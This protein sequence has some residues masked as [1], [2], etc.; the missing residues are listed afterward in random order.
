M[1][2][3]YTPKDVA[4]ILNTHEKTVRKYL[5]DG[6]IEGQKLDGNWKISK[7]V[8]MSYMDK[9]QA[10]ASTA[11]SDSNVGGGVKLS[12]NVEIDV[13]HTKEGHKLA[14]RLMDIIQEN[15]YSSCDFHYNCDKKVA[16]YFLTGNYEFLMEA[17]HIV[18][19]NG[20]EVL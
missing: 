1:K 12:L 4:G 9:I 20:Y 10:S 16:R 14:K 17:L 2:D 6:V 3:F 13:K 18:H 5:R 8:L 15:D 7:D 11:D 19:K